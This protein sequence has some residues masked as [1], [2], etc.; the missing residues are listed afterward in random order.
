MGQKSQLWWNLPAGDS[1]LLNKAIYEVSEQRLRENLKYFT[2]LFE[3]ERYLN[4]PVR[5]LSFG[6]HMKLE[7]IVSLI[8]EPKMM[9]LDELTVGLVAVAQRQIR[10]M[11][12]K[13]GEERGVSLLLTSHYTEDSL[14]VGSIYRTMF[15]LN[16]SIMWSC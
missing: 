3:V 13:T 9:F 5:K 8:H 12:R 6:E 2:K 1:L 14:V 15:G 7:I 16:I 11:L 4:I 10:E